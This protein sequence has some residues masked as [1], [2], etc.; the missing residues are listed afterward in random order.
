MISAC[1]G[2]RVLR[3][4]KKNGQLKSSNKYRITALP[5]NLSPESTPQDRSISPGWAMTARKYLWSSLMT[6]AGLSRV[7]AMRL[8][9]CPDVSKMILSAA[10]NLSN[11]AAMKLALGAGRFE[12]VIPR[13]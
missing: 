3:A 1:I 8:D 6:L 10:K 12:K 9:L 11:D 13:K 4:K 7:L 5:G 2:R